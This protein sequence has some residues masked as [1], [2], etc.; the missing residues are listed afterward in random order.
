M[1]TFSLIQKI[2]TEQLTDKGIEPNV[3][4]NEN[5]KFLGKHGMLDSLDL[6]VIITEISEELNKDPFEEGFQN[7]ETVNDLVLL[8][9]KT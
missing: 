8:Y 1:N 3:E 7:F 4:I 2:I 6:A 5:F 9:D